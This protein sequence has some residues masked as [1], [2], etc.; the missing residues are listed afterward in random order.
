MARRPYNFL[1]FDLPDTAEIENGLISEGELIETILAFRRVGSSRPL[2]ADCKRIRA[3]TNETLLKPKFGKG[4]QYDPRVVHVS[5][6]GSKQG[7]EVLGSTVSWPEFALALKSWVTKLPKNVLLRSISSRSRRVLFFSCCHS[8]VPAKKLRELLRGYFSGCF[9]FVDQNP[10]LADALAVCAMFYR[11][12]DPIYPH[13]DKRRASMRLVDRINAFFG[14][15]PLLDFE[16][17]EDSAVDE[18]PDAAR[19]SAPQR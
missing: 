2:K 17:W 14:D 3:A 10:G 8:A 1:H 4:F 19:S 12:I 6:H 18:V 11:E 9:Y 16:L 13:S 5:G 15:D 7:I